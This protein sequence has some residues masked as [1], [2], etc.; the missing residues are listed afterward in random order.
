MADPLKTEDAIKTDAALPAAPPEDGITTQ[1][2]P[3]LASL[4]GGELAA[5]LT[6]Q[7]YRTAPD[8]T[9]KGW[10]HTGLLGLGGRH[11]L[12]LDLRV[13]RDQ[14]IDLLPAYTKLVQTFSS[15]LCSCLRGKNTD[16]CLHAASPLLLCL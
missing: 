11:L 10:P 6:L 3:A 2:Y 14:E 12:K 5:K 4:P 13:P 15:A 9:T 7:G 8:H 16:Y 1:P